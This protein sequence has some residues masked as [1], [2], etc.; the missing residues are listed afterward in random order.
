M[1]SI[2]EELHSKP[3]ERLVKHSLLTF[4][5][6]YSFR[7]PSVESIA[8]RYLKPNQPLTETTYAPIED[9]RKVRINLLV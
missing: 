7:D 3:S 1:N 9:Y 6:P 5:L 4:L 8:K 2:K